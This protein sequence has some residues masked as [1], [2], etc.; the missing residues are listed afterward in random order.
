MAMTCPNGHPVRES[1]AY[2]PYCMVKLDHEPPPPEPDPEPEPGPVVADRL[3]DAEFRPVVAPVT[4]LEPEP[5]PTPSPRPSSRARVAVAA[6]VVAGALGLVLTLAADGDDD[7]DE[8][9]SPATTS[10]PATTALPATSSITSTSTTTSTTATTA[11]PPTTTVAA[12]PVVVTLGAAC[13]PKAVA[14]GPVPSTAGEAA[15]CVPQEWG[16][17]ESPHVWWPV[18]VPVQGEWEVAMRSCDVD[19][20]EATA[21]GR[22]LSRSDRARDLHLTV[23][24]VAGDGTVLGAGEFVARGVPPG[25]SVRWR[26]DVTG[27]ASAIRECRVAGVRYRP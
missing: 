4:E 19:H 20:D 17:A 12:P 16:V 15:R 9:A 6:A 14:S 26:I 8:A 27:D 21:R 13:D 18:D 1:F 5:E 2:C 7:D 22:I 10:A 25:V 11:P 3:A 23:E 24:F